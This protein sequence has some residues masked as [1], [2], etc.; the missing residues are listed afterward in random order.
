MLAN[1]VSGGFVFLPYV[2][3]LR[4]VMSSQIT[5]RYVVA[6]KTKNGNVEITFPNG[7]LVWFDCGNSNKPDYRNKF[8]T[9]NCF[10]YSIAWDK[11][12]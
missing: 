7:M 1:V 11:A 6:R 9:I 8:V 2:Y 5:L 4:V 10:K 12:N 3:F